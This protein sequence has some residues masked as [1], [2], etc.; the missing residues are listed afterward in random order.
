MTNKEIVQI[1]KTTID[2]IDD[3]IFIYDKA[4]KHNYFNDHPGLVVNS[5]WIIN[6]YVKKLL[7]RYTLHFRKDRVIIHSRHRYQIPPEILYSDPQFINNIRK[8]ILRDDDY[9]KAHH[10]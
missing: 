10:W 3:L 7:V 4:S 8:A 6:I 5:S 9:H 1:G 2:H